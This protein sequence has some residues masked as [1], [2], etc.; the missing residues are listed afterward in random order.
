MDDDLEREKWRWDEYTQI[1]AAT[2]LGVV[3]RESQRGLWRR[4]LSQQMAS[5]ESDW[6]GAVQAWQ[7]GQEMRGESMERDLVGCRGWE[8]NR[9]MMGATSGNEAIYP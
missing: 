7:W 3:L 6:G 1:M 9:R 5:G 8:E 2:P 4:V